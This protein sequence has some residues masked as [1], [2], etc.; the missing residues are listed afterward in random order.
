[1]RNK[2]WW[3]FIS[4][5]VV[6]G[7]SGCATTPDMHYSGVMPTANV[8]HKNVALITKITSGEFVENDCFFAFTHKCRES[9]FPEKVLV[10]NYDRLLSSAITQAGATPTDPTT[11]PKTGWVIVT[12]LSPL[13]PHKHEE[14]LH[15]DLGKTE[16][17]GLIPFF[18]PLRYYHMYINLVDAVT[19]YHDGKPE[20]HARI[21]MHISKNIDGQSGNTAAYKEYRIAQTYAVSRVIT[22]FGHAVVQVDANTKSTA[23]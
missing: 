14:I 20:W 2:L 18:P 16:A 23:E 8:K 19:V 17:M 22:G 3:F 7:L 5:A 11:V 1:M 21:P 4:V 12:D 15:Y 9:G 13:A 6:T 10:K